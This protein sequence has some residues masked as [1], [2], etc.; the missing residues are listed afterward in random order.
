MMAE[1]RIR[2]KKGDT[3]YINNKEFTESVIECKKNDELSE[4]T[5]SCFI[6]L[7][8]RA[9]ER[10]YFRDYRDKEDC[11]QSALVDC[12]KYWRNFDPAKNSMFGKNKDCGCEKRNRIARWRK[13]RDH[14]LKYGWRQCG[15]YNLKHFFE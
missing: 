2:R 14:I 12:V 10:L 13:C 15:V 1:K 7:A 5:I 6:K 3:N 8:N 9:V 4:F 11:I